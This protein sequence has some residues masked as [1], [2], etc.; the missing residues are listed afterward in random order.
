[1][2][3]EEIKQYTHKI[4]KIDIRNSNKKSAETHVTIKVHLEKKSNET[5]RF[6]LTKNPSISE[7]IEHQ[8]LGNDYFLRID[9]KAYNGKPDNVEYVSTYIYAHYFP[10]SLYN[11]IE[12]HDIASVYNFADFIKDKRTNQ[13]DGME[14]P[15]QITSYGYEMLLGYENK[16]L[17]RSLLKDSNNIRYKNPNYKNYI[18][19]DIEKNISD[20]TEKGRF[21][22]SSRYRNSSYRTAPH[23]SDKETFKLPYWRSDTTQYSHGAQP[24]SATS[25]DPSNHVETGY[26][27]DDNTATSDYTDIYDN[28]S[29]NCQQRNTKIPYW[30]AK[31]HKSGLS[32]IIEGTPEFA[33]DYKPINV[34]LN[35]QYLPTSTEYHQHYFGF[36]GENIKPKKGQ[37]V[38]SQLLTAVQSYNPD[39]TYNAQ[40]TAANE[41]YLSEYTNK[42][43]NG[44]YRQTTENKNY[45]VLDGEGL[46]DIN[47]A[48]GQDDVTYRL[49][50]HGNPFDG[51][52][53]VY[54]NHKNIY[55][56]DLNNSVNKKG[57]DW[58]ENECEHYYTYTPLEPS[59]SV[60]INVQLKQHTYY[61]LKYFI[62]IPANAYVEDDS[63][64]VEIRSN[65]TD[66]IQ[67]IGELENVFKKQDKKLRHQ[68]IYHEIP[69][70]TYE[71]DNK[72]VIKGPQ[73]P[74][75]GII[76]INKKTHEVIQNPT[77]EDR[78]NI[79]IDIHDCANDM[80]HFYSMQIAEMVEYSPTIKYTKTGLYIV[81]GDK[82]A[83]KT[84][85]E[86]RNNT[87]V[88]DTEATNAWT[89]QEALNP[90]DTW[91]NKGTTRLPIPL[92]DIYIFFDSDFTIMYN[93]LTTEL[94]YT[95]S[96]F[97]FKFEKFNR[98][99]D[100]EL[101]WISDD[102]IVKLQY[103]RKTKPLNEARIDQ[104]RTNKTNDANIS[105]LLL[106]ELRLF[107]KQKTYFTTGINNTIALKIQDAYG[108][109]ITTGQV[110]C[111]IWTSDKEDETPCDESERCLGWQTPDEYGNV[112]YER[113]NFR[114]FDP[115][116]YTYYLRIRYVNPC[117]K[118]DIIKW[119]TLIFVEERRNMTVYA[120]KCW[121]SPVSDI[122]IPQAITN[123]AIDNN[124]NLVFNKITD[125]KVT[126]QVEI[127]KNIE[128]V[129]DNLQVD[130]I[131]AS[132]PRDLTNIPI[133]I[134][135][136]EDGNLNVIYGTYNTLSND[137]ICLTEKTCCSL[138]ASSIFNNQ[139]NKYDKVSRVHVIKSVEEYPLR[140]DVK[141]RS[142]PLNYNE[143][144]IIDEGYC[145]LSVNDKV[146]QTT[147]VDSNGIADFYL[148]EADLDPGI[149]TI[150]IEYFIHPNEAINYAYFIINCDTGQG[151]DERPGI[152]ITINKITQDAVTQLTNGIYEVEK[153]GIFFADI[154]ANGHTNFSI[155]VK[156][157]NETET[158]KNVTEVLNRHNIAAMYEGN[159]MDKYTI[160]TGN[161]KDSNG[162]DISHLYR[163]TKK[164][165]IVKW[166]DP[167]KKKLI[168]PA[169]IIDISINNQSNLVVTSVSNHEVENEIELVKDVSLADDNLQIRTVLASKLKELDGILT[170]VDLDNNGNIITQ[171]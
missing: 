165:F 145:E 88:P 53:N 54:V 117:Y 166:I 171:R 114:N 148:D 83:K 123:I 151:Y 76:G 29:D 115:T 24:T 50:R 164:D 113:L 23:F 7:W 58:E 74:N 26:K 4:V 33:Q 72:I 28:G 45:E 21:P 93:R 168:V 20:M 143:G 80:I 95:K 63:C 169:G 37:T 82:Y 142:Q 3:I 92:T 162:N 32:P 170:D 6:S 35:Y 128:I 42:I 153:D 5:I 16:P 121:K 51:R 39:G 27:Y 152:P 11:Y 167:I 111:S 31:I 106:G 87:C 163:T 96:N 129:N 141:V 157:N 67:V 12:P 144:N 19:T 14:Y 81:E 55:D 52:S 126:G 2:D 119:K 91:I 125:Y 138:T 73:H 94:S 159:D 140:L 116:R 146:I 133:D 66:G 150:K 104:L 147:F 155:T 132:K 64:Y 41:Q 56:I 75:E 122:I 118:K 112:I 84:L 25:A 22:L 158:L 8:S 49:I 131:L 48:F 61:V 71:I 47:Q 77:D 57:C 68:W 89:T 149:Q 110:E 86:A 130:T 79:L 102:S 78:N 30:E 59:N 154:D 46:N 105:K 160:I 137:Q 136:D 13:W 107:N 99:H 156:R 36:E 60:S 44:T 103:D 108:E 18:Q 15:L 139:N 62:Y 34:Y 161:E 43:N 10:A 134:T 135:L 127:V 124:H 38:N 9:N 101:S 40:Q 17:I 109:A 100:T 85:T 120:N 97:P 69:F 70:Y 90:S 98:V 1:M 65:T